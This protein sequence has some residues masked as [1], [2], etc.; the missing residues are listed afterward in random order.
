MTALSVK[1][2]STS[3]L[4]HRVF[5]PCPH[6][7]KT[8]HK[9]CK[10]AQHLLQVLRTA[11]D[12]IPLGSLPSK[13]FGYAVHGAQIGA[14]RVMQANVINAGLCLSIC[15]SCL[16]LDHTL[17]EPALQFIVML[18]LF[19]TSNIWNGCTTSDVSVS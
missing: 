9:L 8:H 4:Q 14:E 1:A 7:L 19:D 16:A 13:D 12:S 5:T 2:P 10:H 3:A 17:S 11:A 6:T 15:E 18:C